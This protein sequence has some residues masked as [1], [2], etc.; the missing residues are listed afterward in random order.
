MKLFLWG[1]DWRHVVLGQD[2]QRL[3]VLIAR[4]VT[5]LLLEIQNSFNLE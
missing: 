5:L 4:L 2:W 3:Q 1:A